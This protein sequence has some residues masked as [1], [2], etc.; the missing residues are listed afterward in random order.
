MDQILPELFDNQAGSYDSRNAS[1]CEKVWNSVLPILPEV[2]G[3]WVLDAGCGT[4][5]ITERLADD[6]GSWGQIV[7]V[8]ISP[9]MLEKATSRLADRRNITLLRAEMNKVPERDRSFD[10]VVCINVLRHVEDLD[11]ALREWRRLLKPDGELLVVDWD[12]SSFPVRLAHHILKIADCSHKK[13]R[14]S[15]EVVS[16]L[17]NHGFSIIEAKKCS[18]SALHPIWIV[19]AK[20]N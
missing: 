5:M 7:G 4:G 6:V 16:A 18:V 19:K 17:Q 20:K 1:Y 10:V 14:S 13:V 12:G 11:P 3:R 9:K 8:D 2:K 15:E